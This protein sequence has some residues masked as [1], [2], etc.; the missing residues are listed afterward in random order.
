MRAEFHKPGTGKTLS[1]T[2][3]PGV[4]V[5]APA[6]LQKV[7]FF[8]SFLCLHRYLQ[9]TCAPR[10]IVALIPYALKIAYTC[11]AGRE[12][13]LGAQGRHPGRSGC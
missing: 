7:S 5:N 3:A 13:H 2:H 6:S 1:V 8:F 4:D 9:I 11:F 10:Y 12:R